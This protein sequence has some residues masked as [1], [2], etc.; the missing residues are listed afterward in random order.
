MHNFIT[1]LFTRSFITFLFTRSFFL[2]YFQIS[3]YC[4]YFTPLLVYLRNRCEYIQLLTDILSI[5]TLMSSSTFHF[6]LFSLFICLLL[7]FIFTS[8]LFTRKF[9]LFLRCVSMKWTFAVRAYSISYLFFPFLLFNVIFPSCL[10]HMNRRVLSR[11]KSMTY[12]LY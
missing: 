8:I 2:L 1:Y 5:F 12:I 11:K 6:H 7:L 4:L 9:A 3:F 10:L